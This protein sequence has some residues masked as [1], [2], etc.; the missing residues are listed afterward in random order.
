MKIEVVQSSPVLVNSREAARLLSLST[1]TIN[2][3]QS[4]GV[5][6]PVKIGRSTRFR[7]EDILRIAQ[8]GTAK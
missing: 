2:S 3:L 6:R 4:R 1:R 8:E 5:L 7:I